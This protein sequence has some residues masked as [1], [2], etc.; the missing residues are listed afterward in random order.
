MWRYDSIQFREFNPVIL[1][2]TQHRI[3]TEKL[4]LLTWEKKNMDT[5]G[6]LV[7]IYI[8]LINMVNAFTR[9]LPTFK[10]PYLF[11]RKLLQVKKVFEIFC[12]CRRLSWQMINTRLLKGNRLFDMLQKGLD[13]KKEALAQVLS[14]KI[15]EIFKNP[16]FTEH[17]RTTASMTLKYE[18]PIVKSSHQRCSIKK[19]FLKI[20]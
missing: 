10:K 6:I 17:L 4:Y 7:V 12:F 2:W 16:F 13:L 11:Y 5:E 9:H 20:S 19:V 3:N 1:M 8:N 15:C 14:C 18:I